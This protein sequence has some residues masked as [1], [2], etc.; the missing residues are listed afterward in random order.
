MHVKRMLMATIVACGCVTAV[1]AQEAQRPQ[2]PRGTAATQVGGQ[3]VKG[4]RRMSYQGGKWIEVTYSRPLLRQRPGIFGTGA[5]YGKGVS[6]GAPVWRLGADQ[7]TR[8]KTEAPL[9]FGGKTLPAGE[10]SMFVELK[11]NAWTLLF[12][13]WGAQQKFDRN[14]KTALWGSYNYTPDK[15]VLRVPMKVESIPMSVDQLSIGFVDVTAT[16]GRLA[17]WWDT[18]QASVAF[19]V[20]S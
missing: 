1:L 7:S 19:T 5:E 15:D 10:Y 17:I 9:V 16:G 8:F 20:G 11:E 14:D 12:S 3:W 13:S 2:S 4:E 6:A 18:T